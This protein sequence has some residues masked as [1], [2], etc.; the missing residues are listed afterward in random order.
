MTATPLVSSVSSVPAR[1]RMALAPADTTATGVRP[2]SVRS[3]ETSRLSLAPRWTPPMPPVANTRCRQALRAAWWR[4]PWWR[5]RAGCHRE[6]HIVGR[7]LE[8]A[9]AVA[10][11]ASCVVGKPDLQ[12][13]AKHRDGRRHRTL[14]SD[15][16]LDRAGDL[17]VLRIRH[18][19]GDDGRFQCHDGAAARERCGNLGRD[20]QRGISQLSELLRGSFSRTFM[21][22]HP[23][24][25][26]RPAISALAGNRQ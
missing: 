21:A 23:G 15:D 2:S 8:H 26:P 22:G 9:R 16:R 10:S 19:V 18:A 24:D 25:R 13:A 6:R 14:L 5:R 20:N 1:S 11:R 4:R 17:E 3:A 12:S 7:Q